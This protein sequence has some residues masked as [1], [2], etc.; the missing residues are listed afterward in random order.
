MKAPS[1]SEPQVSETF[2]TLVADLHDP[3]LVSDVTG[4]VHFAN[5]A[6]RALL[7]RPAEQAFAGSLLDLLHP[8]DRDAFLSRARAVL[9][10]QP[11]EH[12]LPVRLGEAGRWS[13][14]ALHLSPMAGV[15]GDPRLLLRGEVPPL[16]PPI[17]PDLMA[18]RRAALLGELVSGVGHEFNNLLTAIRGSTDLVLDLALPAEARR[19]H[20]SDLRRATDRAALLTQQLL[21]LRLRR[22]QDPQ[23]YDVNQV[24]RGIEALLVCTMGGGI[25]LSVVPD[26]AA[27]AVMGDPGDAELVLLTLAAAARKLGAPNGVIEIS[28]GTRR[29]AANESTVHGLAPGV[30]VE[31]TVRGFRRPAGNGGDDPLLL[32]DQATLRDVMR[33][34]EGRMALGT[35]PD[36]NDEIVLSLPSMTPATRGQV[37]RETIL[38]VDDEPA[39][40][41]LTERILVRAGYEVRASCGGDEMLRVVESMT[42]EAALVITDLSMPDIP[43]DALARRLRERQPHLRVLFM[44]GDMAGSG[45]PGATALPGSALLGKPFTQDELLRAV[46]ILLGERPSPE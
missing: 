29:M 41:R 35:G 37:G 5:G 33:T 38:V 24:V 2:R 17:D 42:G 1:A 26:P 28:T 20:E 34:A 3:I 15:D 46:H 30:Y 43:G 23:P 39:L 44:S 14:L 32:R 7:H 16:A 8:G 18:L 36:G 9:E 6:G 31:L 4:R 10:G 27:P 12:R 40:R 11:L 22:P 13:P 21:D 25:R 19:R 45:H